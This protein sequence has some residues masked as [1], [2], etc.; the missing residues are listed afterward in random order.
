MLALD[1]RSRLTR[2]LDDGIR[3]MLLD[4]DFDARFL[5]SGN[6]DEA[7]EVRRN[8]VVLSRN[9]LYLVDAGVIRALTVEWQGLL[10]TMLFSALFDA[11]V[12]GTKHFFVV[13]RAVREAHR[14]IFARL[15][16]RT[17]DSNPVEQAT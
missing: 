3:G 4:H 15:S 7:R 17:P 16:W 13:C 5:V 12:D 1:L 9:E 8:P 6:Y 11:V 14:S 2:L 10:N